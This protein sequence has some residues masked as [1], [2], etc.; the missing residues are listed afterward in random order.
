MVT[1]H[2][3]DL[4]KV[5]GETLG[6]VWTTRGNPPHGQ[7]DF[8]PLL[9]EVYEVIEGEVQGSLFATSLLTQGHKISVGKFVPV[10]PVIGLDDTHRYA[11]RTSK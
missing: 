6:K 8:Y 1:Q 4:R 2:R 3:D 5:R 7:A 9:A 10:K 11:P